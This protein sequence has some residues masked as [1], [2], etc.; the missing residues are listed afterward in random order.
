MQDFFVG[1]F[2]P[3]FTHMGAAAIVGQFVVF[4]QPLHFFLVDAAD[5]ADHMGGDF[6]KR[7]IAEQP[8]FH[9]NTRK[10]PDIGRHFGHFVVGELD[11]QRNGFKVAAF[12]CLFAKAFDVAGVDVHQLG[13]LAEGLLQIFNF[14]RCEFQRV[15]GVI[16]R[17]H[18]AVAIHNQPTVGDDRRQGD[19][20]ILGQ[21]GKVFVLIHLQPGKAGGQGDKTQQHGGKGQQ[22]A[23]LKLVFRLLL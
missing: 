7:I 18:H 1:V 21:G 11:L 12:F 20:V 14:V 13:Q 9:L 5:I 2:Q 23:Q 3:G 10:A 22:Q 16:L 17:Q 15:G 4:F 19:A 8:C 6:F